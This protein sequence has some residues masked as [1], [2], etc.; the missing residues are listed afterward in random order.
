MLQNAYVFSLVLGG[1]LLGAS[2]FIGDHDA[3]VDV[4][5]DIDIDAGPDHG[6]LDVLGGFVGALTSLRFWT[7]FLAFFGLTGWSF[8]FF[9]LLSETSRFGVSLGTGA[10]I[11]FVTVRLFKALQAGEHTTAATA[12]DFVG[13]SGRVLVRI[14]SSGEVGKVRLELKGTTVDIVAETED[15]DDLTAGDR[16]LVV[17]MRG[18]TALVTRLETTSDA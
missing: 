17:E 9:D 6:G 11:G 3:D 8:S 7:F 4:D 2:I 18:T 1:V 16:A 12:K 10:V 15:A 13:K 5:A 14:A